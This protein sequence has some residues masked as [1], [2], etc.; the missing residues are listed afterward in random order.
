[1]VTAC[2]YSLPVGA[3]SVLVMLARGGLLRAR[4]PGLGCTKSEPGPRAQDLPFLD[5]DVYCGFYAP[6]Y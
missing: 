3:C 1:M 6:D 5:I 4:G 2:L